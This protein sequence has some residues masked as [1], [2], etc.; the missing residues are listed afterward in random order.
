MILE[1]TSSSTPNFQRG[2][3][4]TLFRRFVAAVAATHLVHTPEYLKENNR[5]IKRVILAVSDFRCRTGGNP[6]F[7]F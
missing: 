4:R 1:M 5:N 2:R 6:K 3:T 7:D